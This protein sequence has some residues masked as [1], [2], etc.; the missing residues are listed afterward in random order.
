MKENSRTQLTQT[1]RLRYNICVLG[2]F[3]KIRVKNLLTAIF[4]SGLVLLSFKIKVQPVQAQ[5]GPASTSQFKYVGVNIPNLQTYSEQKYSKTFGYLQSCGINTVR[6]FAIEQGNRD[7]VANLATAAQVAAQYGIKLVVALDDYAGGSD[8]LPAGQVHANPQQWYDRTSGNSF[9]ET[10]HLGMVSNAANQLGS[11]TYSSVAVVEFANEP[12]CQGAPGCLTSYKDWVQTVASP[13]S[14]TGKILSIGTGMLGDVDSPGGGLQEINSVAGIGQVSTHWYPETMAGKEDDLANAAQIARS[15]NKEILL[16]EVGFKCDNNG[17]CIGSTNDE[18][19]ARWLAKVFQLAD[20]WGY[21]GVLYWTFG[22]FRDGFDYYAENGE[23]SWFAA[24]PGAT[25]DPFCKAFRGEME[26]LDFNFQAESDQDSLEDDK[27]LFVYPRTTDLNEWEKYLANTNVYCAPTQVYWPEYDGTNPNIPDCVPAGVAQTDPFGWLG[28]SNPNIC[29]AQ[30]YPVF[31]VVEEY[32]YTNVSVPLWRDQEGDISIEIDL[33]RANPEST[34]EKM[35]EKWARADFAPQFYLTTP[36][37][38][39]WNAA[40]Y[41]DYVDLLCQK[42][43]QPVNSAGDQEECPA[44]HD[45]TLENGETIEFEVA[46]EL[47]THQNCAKIGEAITEDSRL[48]KIVRNLDTRA[49]KIF[50]M[51]F[52]VQHTQLYGQTTDTIMQQFREKLISIWFKDS[53]PQQTIGNKIKIT[54]V[55]FQTGIAGNAILSGQTDPYPIDPTDPADLA[56]SVYDTDSPNVYNF[57]NPWWQTYLPALPLHTTEFLITM[58]QATVQENYR[59]MQQ[60]QDALINGYRVGEV[61]FMGKSY[62]TDTLISCDALQRADGSYTDCLPDQTDNYW[63]DLQDSFPEDFQPDEEVLR[64]L[65]QLVVAR[66]NSG[67]QRTK[68]FDPA[69]GVGPTSERSFQRCEIDQENIR[70]GE[71]EQAGSV[72]YNLLQVLKQDGPIAALQSVTNELKAKVNWFPGDFFAQYPESRNYLVLPDEAID[73]DLAQSYFAPMF[74]SPEMYADI[75]SG[76]NDIY[77]FKKLATAEADYGDLEPYLSAFMRTSGHERSYDSGEEGYVL[78]EF[79]YHPLGADGQ[80]LT[81]VTSASSQ[82]W[83]PYPATEEQ[84]SPANDCFYSKQIEKSVVKSIGNLRDEDPNENLEVPGNLAA[85]HEFLRRMA[86]TPLHLVRSYPGLEAFYGGAKDLLFE[87]TGLDLQDAGEYFKTLIGGLKD[88][89][90][91]SSPANMCGVLLV[92]KDTA[93]EHG[94]LLRQIM[95]DKMIDQLQSISESGVTPDI[96]GTCP[97]NV[98]CY[99]FM[100]QTLLT[101]PVGNGNLYIDPL[102]A[103]SVVLTENGLGRAGSA[104]HFSCNITAFSAYKPG[105]KVDGYDCTV[106]TA[107]GQEVIN[108]LITTLT[109]QSFAGRGDEIIAACVD[110]RASRDVGANK[111]NYFVDGLA[112]F[113]S[114]VQSQYR[115][116]N[117]DYQTLQ[118][119]GYTGP[120]EMIYNRLQETAT[121]YAKGTAGS[122][123]YNSEYEQQLR[124][125]SDVLS[126][127]LYSCAP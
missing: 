81:Q 16:G 55:W 76:E 77:P 42:N 74:L 9:I 48:A 62:L 92:D 30:D 32:N 85:L 119:Y 8:T 124:D 3:Y 29:E 18:T 111:E 99:E 2:R 125:V 66:V 108:P 78:M 49:P 112:C 107:A 95:T 118:S 84:P 7:G 20:E 68:R 88:T 50:K 126:N 38:Q 14:R 39:C 54:P 86:F 106:Q 44:K 79:G 87:R 104:W 103:W 17:E 1:S 22:G 59:L 115:L 96:I 110:P 33:S 41:F 75:M 53:D 117:N 105:A 73:I 89:Y 70:Y 113:I 19:R 11:G 97:G 57:S 23:Q 123:E 60:F 51:G 35:G 26:P 37:Q 25:E 47:V 94:T 64:Q 15:L 56:Q 34:L 27:P 120:G 4:L 10:G 121:N 65:S 43:P 98:P 80:C 83:F 45:I 93:F 52:L 6:T 100:I 31:D 63:Q 28:G 101:N 71:S 90:K 91:S 21:D 67:V 122:S 82:Q 114:V 102:V 127:R 109:S 40:S 13:L 61:T 69:T 58:K 24:N 46:K 36:E 116:G 12:H 72:N 5:T